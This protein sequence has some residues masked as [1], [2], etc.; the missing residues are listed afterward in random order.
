MSGSFIYIYACLVYKPIYSLLKFF[1]IFV[2]VC[3]VRF[4]II[5][6]LPDNLLLFTTR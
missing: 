3:F 5:I 2:C 4:S 1:N 6:I